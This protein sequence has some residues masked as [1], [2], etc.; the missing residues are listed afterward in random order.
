MRE[1]VGTMAQLG[2]ML[3]FFDAYR[4]E[5]RSFRI[6]VL[7]ATAAL[8]AHY[9][10]P[11]RW[12]KPLFVAISI[13]GMVLVNGLFTSAGVLAV[14]AVLLVL[15][16]APLSWRIRVGL[17]AALALCLAVLRSRAGSGAEATLSGVIPIVATMFMFRMILYLYERKHVHGREPLVDTLSYFFI[18]PNYVFPHFPVVDYRAFQRGYFARGIDEIQQAGLKMIS[19]GTLHLLLYRV[20][21]RLLLI[22]PDA[23]HGPLSLAGYLVCNY[24]LYLRVSGQFHMACG[25]LHLFGFQLPETHRQYLLAS[26]FTDY[27]RRINIYWKDF[28]VRIVFNPVAFRLKHCPQPVALAGATL[29]VFV[30]TW[31][32]HAYQ[33]YWLRGVWGFS[34]PDGLFWG[35]LGFLVLLNVQ[36]DARRGSRRVE[37]PSRSPLALAVRAARIAVTFFTIALLWSLWNSPSVGAW[38]ALLRRGVG[39]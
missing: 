5:T 33:T 30:V 34:A 39:F 36:L 24:L 28:M 7:L 27:W 21:D 6:L 10:A 38:V 20:I 29:V 8:P 3:A 12:K 4:I 15:A 13:L 9:L 2:L 35:I 31:L 22:S 17:I 25:L 14:S 37:A 19:R 23:V 16:T 18:L 32:L 11:Y 26:G 1:F